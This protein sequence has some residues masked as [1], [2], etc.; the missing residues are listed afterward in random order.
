[1]FSLFRASVKREAHGAEI[2]GDRLSEPEVW[3]RRTSLCL[4]GCAAAVLVL[5]LQVTAATTSKSVTL[6]LVEKQTAFNFIDN[7]PRQGP[8]QP[9][10]MGDQFVFTSDL[11][12]KSGAH[13]GVVNVSCTVVTGGSNPSGPCYGTLSFKGGEI[14]VIARVVFSSNTTEGAIVGGTGVYRGATGYVISVARGEDSPYSDDALHVA[15][16]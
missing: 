11:I 10:L 13:A 8:R 1:M 6:H 7:P 4:A 14:M 15:L 2:G 9:P 16:P 12:T 5:P 3:K